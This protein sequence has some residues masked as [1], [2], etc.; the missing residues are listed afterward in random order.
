MVRFNRQSLKVLTR[1]AAEYPGLVFV[2]SRFRRSNVAAGAGLHLNKT[3]GVVFPRYQVKVTL[4]LGAAPITRHDR[5]TA[6]AEVKER[7]LFSSTPQL[8]MR[9]AGGTPP[10]ANRQVVA[11][12][13]KLLDQ[14]ESEHAL[15]CDTVS[16]RI[17][18]FA[19]LATTTF[20][21]LHKESRM[22]ITKAT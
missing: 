15:H 8:Q 7:C 20:A 21:A 22:Q 16:T 1:H 10:Q 12:V 18:Y 9:R 13:N 5:V 11:D 2:D 17:S 14:A 6:A 19:L 3:E 4:R